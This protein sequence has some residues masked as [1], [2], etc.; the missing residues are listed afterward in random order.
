MAV[1]QPGNRDIHDIEADVARRL[2]AA[3][4][5][6][7][8]E[9]AALLL[10]EM[11]GS[12]APETLANRLALERMVAQRV[13][14]VPLEYVLGWA[15]FDGIRV[16]VGDGV[17][18][19][20]HRTELLVEAA[21]SVTRAGD[22]VVDLCCGSGAIGLALAGRVPGI[23]LTAADIDPRAVS[24]A[25]VNLEPVGGH[26]F[27]GDLYSTLPDNLRGRIRTLVCNTPY[28]PTA[29]IALL[30]PEARL[31]E[32]LGTLDGGDDG[33]DIQR[34]VADD[35]LAWLAPGGTLFVETSEAQAGPSAQI[36]RAAGLAA[37]TIRS[38][39]GDATV[40]SARR[41]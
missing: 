2:R 36:M 34:R 5:V 28:V 9:E 17:F 39:E 24:W 18:V 23:E 11:L 3:G 35:A 41:A 10:A 40:V 14:G 25:R 19:P 16:R 22:T 7:A 26:V 15:L 13:S 37:E 8:E 12:E 29:D 6:F 30:P 32:P 38:A 33:L 4:C 20:R 27:E 21:A 1:T 31:Y